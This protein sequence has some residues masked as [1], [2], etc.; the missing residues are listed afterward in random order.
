[1]DSESNQ[2]VQIRI[3]IISRANPPIVLLDNGSM[4]HDLNEHERKWQ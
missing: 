2:H 1:M 4:V 3:P